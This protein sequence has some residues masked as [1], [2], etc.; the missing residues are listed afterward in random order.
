LVV[1]FWK[2]IEKYSG[3]LIEKFVFAKVFFSF[4]SLSLSYVCGFWLSMF[5]G[6][7]NSRW[8]HR[9]L[10][11]LI[12]VRNVQEKNSGVYLWFWA[13]LQ[14]SDF[15]GS[16]PKDRGFESQ[17]RQG[18]ICWIMLNL[19]VN[20]LEFDNS[21]RMWKKISIKRGNTHQNSFIPW[22]K[23]TIWVDWVSHLY[24]SLVGIC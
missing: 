18:A 4:L 20:N 15:N 5:T 19:P 11:K 13:Q 6:R 24:L 14:E 16:D 21:E 2:I 8:V 23:R 7:K 9:E 10:T 12:F 1:F 3:L 17:V 22:C